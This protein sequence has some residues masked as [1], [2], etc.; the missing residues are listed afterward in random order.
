[1]QKKEHD[2]IKAKQEALEAW[3]ELPQGIPSREA[4]PPAGGGL[5]Y[6]FRWFS[7]IFDFIR[8]HKVLSLLLL[9]GTVA[10]VIVLRVSL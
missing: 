5:N 10:V 6:L 1:M 2:Q 4:L 7:G 3:A 8:D 9:I